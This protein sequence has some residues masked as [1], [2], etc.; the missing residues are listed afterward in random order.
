MRRAKAVGVWLV[1]ALM[2]VA[3]AG[4]G[5][6]KFTVPAWERMFRAWGYPD[7]FYLVIGAVEVLGGLALL[8]PKVAAPAAVVLMVVM[9]AAAITRLTNGGS[10]VGELVFS[11]LLGLIAW[12][13]REHFS[14]VL[15]AT[16]Y[17][18]RTR[19]RRT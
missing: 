5:V 12:S 7:H 3:M 1:Q 18:P 10:V 11:A 17:V 14:H 2:C 4:T 15:R 13:R 19:A 9:V 16:S 6:Q 8:V